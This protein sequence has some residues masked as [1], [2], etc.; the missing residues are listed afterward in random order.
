[1]E[2]LKKRENT[3]KDEPQVTFNKFEYKPI[4]STFEKQ[5]IVSE[6]IKALFEGKIYA[7][8]IQNMQEVDFSVPKGHSD[9]KRRETP[10]N[11]QND[12]LAFT[13]VP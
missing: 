10:K 6:D 3:L 7:P 2:I 1:M 12:L 4:Q 9:R 8:E 13:N 11:N 5:V